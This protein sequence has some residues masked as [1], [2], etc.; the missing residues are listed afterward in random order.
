M[1]YSINNTYTHSYHIGKKGY[2]NKFEKSLK[3]PFLNVLSNHMPVA[4]PLTD[5]ETKVD[6]SEIVV[7]DNIELSSAIV[8]ATAV[9][10][11]GNANA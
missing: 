5:N 3:L 10:D 4:K 11:S 8:S 2:V 6:T 7:S 9:G 1:S